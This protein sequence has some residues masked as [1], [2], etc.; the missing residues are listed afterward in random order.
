[1]AVDNEVGLW[2]GTWDEVQVGLLKTLRMF[3]YWSQLMHDAARTCLDPF[4][5]PGLDQRLEC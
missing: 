4:H 1:M 2:A 5:A 3:N